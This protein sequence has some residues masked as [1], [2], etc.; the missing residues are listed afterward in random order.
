VTQAFVIDRRDNVATAL[1]ELNRDET[2]ECD[3]RPVVTR[4][5][6]PPGHKVAL[7]D[8]APGSPV[9]KYGSPM[10]LAT[11]AIRAGDH[12]H[13]HNVVSTRGRGDL[14]ARGALDGEAR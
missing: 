8:I 1:R 4:Q 6:I 5:R 14:G 3:G 12:V 9:V 7:V 10:G 11:T 13:T 2:I